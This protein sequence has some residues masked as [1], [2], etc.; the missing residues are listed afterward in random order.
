MSEQLIIEE[1]QT[2]IEDQDQWWDDSGEAW[3]FEEEQEIPE[4]QRSCEERYG[5]P[6]GSLE[7][8]LQ[9]TAERMYSGAVAR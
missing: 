8:Y 2:M 6:E 4:W 7:V 3:F 5:I 1:V 9:A